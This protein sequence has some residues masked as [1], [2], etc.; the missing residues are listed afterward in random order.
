MLEE[1]VGLKKQLAMKITEAPHQSPKVGRAE[2]AYRTKDHGKENCCLQGCEAVGC[3]CRE[4]GG[5]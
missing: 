5:Y 1:L 2:K 4:E 3:Q